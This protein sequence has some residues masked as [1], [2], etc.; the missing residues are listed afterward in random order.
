MKSPAS[1][2]KCTRLGCE[3]QEKMG[4]SFL[5]MKNT[6]H[7]VDLLQHIREKLVPRGSAVHAKNEE[8]RAHARRQPR[9]HHW[10]RGI[11]CDLPKEIHSLILWISDL[12][13]RIL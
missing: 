3:R 2:W 11:A 1:M 9:P 5:K 6:R 7:L 13:S 8:E 10:V 4:R 12:R